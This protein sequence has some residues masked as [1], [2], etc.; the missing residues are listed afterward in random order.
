MIDCTERLIL[1][2][3][4][5]A[6]TIYAFNVFLIGDSIDRQTVREW[7]SQQKVEHAHKKISND[8]IVEYEWGP[9]ALT[10]TYIFYHST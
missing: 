1:V 3:F 2:I 9:K 5:F 4:T 7:C 6:S 10:Y 8:S